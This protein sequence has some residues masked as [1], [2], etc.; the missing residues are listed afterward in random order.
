MTDYSPSAA[1]LRAVDKLE[2]PLPEPVQDALARYDA[3]TAAEAGLYAQRTAALTDL[4]GDLTAAGA[5]LGKITSVLT[6]RAAGKLAILVAPDVRAA[7]TAATGQADAALRRAIVHN[8]DDLI[9]GWRPTVDRAGA[10]LTDA[11]AALPDVGDLADHEAV[12]R[13]GADAAEHWGRATRAVDLLVKVGQLLD[14]LNSLGY[15]LTPEPGGLVRG[16][17]AR[18]TTL[19]WPIVKDQQARTVWSAVRAGGTVRLHTGNELREIMAGIVAAREADLPAMERSL[20]REGHHRQPVPFA[21]PA[22]W[23]LDAA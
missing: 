2:L 16:E 4:T 19:T 15:N 9:R 12:A 20:R 1:F 8:G 5:D 21:T 17:V 3:L 6:G 11:A 18:L 7:L 22:S 14:A 23:P 10:D 13:S